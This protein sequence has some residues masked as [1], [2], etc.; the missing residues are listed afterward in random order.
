MS[1]PSIENLRE[2]LCHITRSAISK[3][4]EEEREREAER[5]EQQ[6]Q[7]EIAQ[8]DALWSYFKI[9]F[10]NAAK[11]GE[12]SVKIIPGSQVQKTADHFTDEAIKHLEDK[13]RGVSLD[14]SVVPE[15]DGG[16]D[17]SWKEFWVSWK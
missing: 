2:E 8:F 5:H 10:T 12:F 3:K 13:V 9:E 14:P 17:N 1:Q 11:K 6:V 15:V 16:G 7:K 4:E